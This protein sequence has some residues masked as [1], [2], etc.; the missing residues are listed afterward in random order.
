MNEEAPAKVYMPPE[1][2]QGT[3]A[4]WAWNANDE[5][6]TTVTHNGV[7]FDAPAPF[8]VNGGRI[9]DMPAAADN[10]FILNE[11][12]TRV[13]C[14]ADGDTCQFIYHFRRTFDGQIP[15]TAAVESMYDFHPFYQV[16]AL[17][18][19]GFATEP[20]QL[21]LGAYSALAASIS[22]AAALAMLF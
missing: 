19:K 7:A 14:P 15:L 11:T 4:K 16:N 6:A 12:K 20:L 18:Q 22:A 5:A 3:Y 1:N 8:T 17:R 2:F 9:S 10:E 13:N 21:A